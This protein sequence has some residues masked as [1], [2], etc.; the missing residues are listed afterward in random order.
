MSKMARSPKGLS[1]PRIGRDLRGDRELA[2]WSGEDL[3]A[4]GFHTRDDGERARR[5][6]RTIVELVHPHIE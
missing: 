4:S 2:S 6:A 3:K 5:D 1:A